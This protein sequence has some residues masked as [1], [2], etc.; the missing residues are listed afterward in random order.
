MND[1]FYRIAVVGPGALGCLLA[2]CLKEAG[3]EVRLV[4]Y[5]P[6][7]ASFLTDQGIHLKTLDG[8]EKVVRVPCAFAPEVGPCNLTILT[9][10]TYQTGAAASSLPFLLAPDGVALT[11]QNGLGNLEEMARAAGPERL[12]AGVTMLGVTGE[13]WGKITFAGQ[14]PTLVGLPHGSR[15]SRGQIQSVVARLN[16]AGL[17]AHYRA[18][19]ETALWEKLLINVG[20]NP[21]TALLRVRNGALPE[22]PEAWDLA[23]AAVLEAAQVARASGI[24]LTG[25]PLERLRQVCRNTAANRSSMLQDVLAGRPTEIN[26]LNGQ[27]TIRGRTL[28]I[29]TPTNDLLTKLLQSLGRVGEGEIG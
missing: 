2:A 16:R 9:V 23:A 1:T 11:L 7:R 3:E 25:D 28:G 14:G 29:P 27:I 20:I 6:E 12:L 4:D 17:E 8:A 13:G 19:I 26:A 22:I 18:D 21:L 5:R 24:N 15:V 10:K